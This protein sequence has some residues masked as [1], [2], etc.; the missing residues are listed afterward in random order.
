L[1]GDRDGHKIAHDFTLS[2]HCCHHFLFHWC[3]GSD[4]DDDDDDDDKDDD[5]DDDSSTTT[6]AD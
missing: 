6:P 5:D 4:D 3:H 2:I 1:L